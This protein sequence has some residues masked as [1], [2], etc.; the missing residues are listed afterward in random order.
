[1]KVYQKVKF[2]C[3]HFQQKSQ[4]SILYQSLI[5]PNTNKIMAMKE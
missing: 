1:M 5:M 3:R 2:N 4:H